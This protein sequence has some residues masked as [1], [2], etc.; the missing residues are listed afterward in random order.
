MR[1]TYKFIENISKILFSTVVLQLFIIVLAAESGAFLPSQTVAA[2]EHS[3]ASCIVALGG[4]IFMEY[5]LK[6]ENKQ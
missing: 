4:Q 2:L 6:K 1:F 3:A 5:V